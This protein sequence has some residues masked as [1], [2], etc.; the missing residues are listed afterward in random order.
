MGTPKLRGQCRDSPDVPND[1]LPV[2]TG[3]SDLTNCPSLSLVRPHARDGVLMHRKQLGFSL[4]TSTT[5]TCTRHTPG[6]GVLKGVEGRT[7]QPP[8]SARA[9]PGRTESRFRSRR[10]VETSDELPSTFVSGE[11]VG[12]AIM[13]SSDDGI[14]RGPYESDER[15]GGYSD[16]TDCRTRS[17]IDDANGAVV[18]FASIINFTSIATNNMGLPANARTSPEG[19]KETV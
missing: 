14:L 16:C 8:R 15:E 13:T 5:S 1:Q 3:R 18:T 7:V 12:L 4:R 10:V 6:I 9:E 19:E 2:H 17:R 11:D